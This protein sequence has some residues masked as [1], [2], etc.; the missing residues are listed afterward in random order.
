MREIK[1]SIYTSII[2]P[3]IHPSSIHTQPT[4]RKSN[5][6]FCCQQL[7]GE[8]GFYHLTHCRRS[9]VSHWWCSWLS[10]RS[11]TAKVLSSILGW[12]ICF[13]RVFAFFL[14]S[15]L[16]NQKRCRFL[17]SAFLV[18]DQHSNVCDARKHGNI[19]T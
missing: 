9:Y 11:N 3:S 18:F 4:N 16:E 5:E 8:M 1:K 12:C 6:G 10:H 2:D 15:L 17:F 13:L 7:L 14:L 19:V